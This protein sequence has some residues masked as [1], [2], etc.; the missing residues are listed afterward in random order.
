[1][2]QNGENSGEKIT[3]LVM[4]VL[5]GNTFEIKVQTSDVNRPSIERIKIANRNNPSPSTLS[6]ILAK[7]DLEKRITGRKVECEILHR[8]NDNKLIAS[9]SNRFLKSPFDISIGDD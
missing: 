4:N 2:S 5:D 8:D 6:G 7:L 9:I 1:M 3:G